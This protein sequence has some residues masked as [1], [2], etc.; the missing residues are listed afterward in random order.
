MGI[1]KK[2]YFCCQMAEHTFTFP[3]ENVDPKEK[4]TKKWLKQYCDAA[5][6]N[7]VNF[8]SGAL[9]WANRMKYDEYELYARGSQPTDKYKKTFNNGEDGQNKL[10]VNDWRILPIMTKLLTV[11]SGM[12]DSLDFRPQIDPIDDLAKDEIEKALLENEAKIAIKEQLKS[13]GAPKEVMESPSLQFEHGEADDFDS[14]AV[15]ELGFRHQT[16]LELEQAC[17][18]IANA[19]NFR[20]LMELWNADLV[21]YGVC[22]RNE[23]IINDSEIK[24]TREDPR[25]LIMSF[26]QNPDFSDW[27]YVG[28]IRTI[29]VS[30]IISISNGQV[31]KD[32]IEEMWQLGVSGKQQIPSFPSYNWY[33]SVQQF[34]NRGSL[35][36]LE[37]QIRSTDK[38]TL[39]SRDTK[40]G[41]KAHNY[42]NP[43]KK[44]SKDN[45]YDDIEIENVY[46]CSW[47]VGTDIMYNIGK[48]RNTL[49]SELNPSIVEP[50]I[51]V[52]GCKVWN[53]MAKSRVEELISYADSIQYAFYR[54]Q[55]VLNSTVQDGY[56][57]NFDAIESIDLG[58][59]GTKWTPKDVLDLFFDRGILVYRGM[60]L[61]TDPRSAGLPITPISNGALN[62][63]AEYWNMLNSNIALMR[64]TLGL[65]DL[66]DAS[67]P[68]ERT[69]T[70]VAKA[71]QMGT[72]NALSDIYSAQRRLV[73]D[74]TK[75]TIRFAQYLVQDGNDGFLRYALGDGSMKRLRYIKDI[76]K[77]LYS[78]E[79]KENPTPDEI[80]S[81]NEQIKIGQQSGEITTADVLMLDN[82]SNLKQKQAFLAV[83]IKKNREEQQKRAIE[84]SQANAQAQLQ[85]AMGAEQARQQTIQMQIQLQ[86]EA[87]LRRIEAEKERD[88]MIEQIRLE[89]KRID[90][91]G[92]VSSAVV[93]AEG[94]NETNERDNR[95]KLLTNKETN[96]DLN[97][98]KI[99]E[100]PYKSPVLPQTAN[101]K[102]LELQ[103]FDLTK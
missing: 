44:R 29:P 66:T 54:I 18:V 53:M 99:D 79:I 35:Y 24:I 51:R 45:E 50:S 81:L 64:E 70:E 33:P 101:N 5:F 31:T 103:E 2:S 85:A 62:K 34:Y 60:T 83:R 82:M 14:L 25:N 76:P 58:A 26:C 55:H 30:E 89:G 61:G 11:V 43:F 1:V 71:A 22:V 72:K 87:D 93:Q 4:L 47:V 20:D 97:V 91:E 67:T 46:C 40:V 80:L 19:N 36:V 92:R 16:A 98:L 68:N 15:R 77:Y 13:M 17:K 78:V 23:R 8:P 75:D 27:R 21:K 74:V 12:L 10:L 41:N 39:E 86:L 52:Y 100:E 49:R 94:R 28:V 95:V 42:T 37:I 48:Q 102:P 6:Y 69:L 88:M 96:V 73:R 9:G 38:M 3:D 57:I 32:Q 59:G 7:Y 63:L 56:A 84:Q 90:A 65:N